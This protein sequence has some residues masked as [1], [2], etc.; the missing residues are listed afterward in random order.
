[1]ELIQKNVIISLNNSITEQLISSNFDRSAVF[2]SKIFKVIGILDRIKKS[3]VITK[4]EEFSNT[5]R[6][7]MMKNVFIPEFILDAYMHVFDSYYQ[8]T[9]KT[10]PNKRLASEFLII[11]LQIVDSESQFD[12]YKLGNAGPVLVKILQKIA[13]IVPAFN[14]LL[15]NV[16]AMERK[17]LE[18]ILEHEQINRSV[19]DMHPISVGS[20]GQVHRYGKN[21]CI[22]I[23]KPRTVYFALVEKDIILTNPKYSLLSTDTKEYLNFMCDSLID[24]THLH[25]EYENAVKAKKTYEVASKIYVP[26][27]KSP[28]YNTVPYLIMEYV[29]GQTIDRVT[30]Q[31]DCRRIMELLFLLVHRWFISA[32]IGSGFIDID[33]HAGNMI[34]TAD[35][36]LAIIDF[37]NCIVLSNKYKC[38][39]SKINMLH[40]QNIT[41]ASV[42]SINKLLDTLAGLCDVKLEETTLATIIFKYLEHPKLHEVLLEIIKLNPLLGKCATGNIVDYIKGINI[43]NDTLEL[44]HSRC[45]FTKPLMELNDI[46]KSADFGF[47]DAIDFIKTFIVCSVMG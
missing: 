4:F 34:Y 33:L 29:E 13:R 38:G 26:K 35:G 31:R 21:Q 7:A 19:F 47:V 23:I 17:E 5:I 8:A 41:N 11:L 46:M 44:V 15:S 32:H 3:H 39:L 37:G 30:N 2:K 14:K 10:F 20:F 18:L 45:N 12:M 36:R 9:L 24:E 28:S 42:K 6:K 1:M 40:N 27:M 22:K 25:H 43:I 16:P